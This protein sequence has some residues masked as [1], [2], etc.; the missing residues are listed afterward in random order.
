QWFV[1]NPFWLLIAMLAALFLLSGL[2]RAIAGLTEKLWLTLLKLPFIL[3]QTV[4][5]SSLF[6][7]LRPFE[8]S[9]VASLTASP[10]PDRLT[11]ILNRL[12]ALR[13]EQDELLQEVRLLLTDQKNR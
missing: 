12:E 1:S 8:K 2:L 3:V 13:Q 7:L 11:E 6:L 5:R 4:W 10:A 9:T